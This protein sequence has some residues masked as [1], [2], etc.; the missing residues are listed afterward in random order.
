[1]ERLAEQVSALGPAALGS[2]LKGLESAIGPRVALSEK[3]QATTP[4][5]TGWVEPL[6]T[7][8]LLFAISRTGLA[9]KVKLKANDGRRAEVIFRGGVGN[10][11]VPPSKPTRPP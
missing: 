3:L 4:L 9:G 5:L 2:V 6:G 7:T 10:L 8:Y 11:A 1:M